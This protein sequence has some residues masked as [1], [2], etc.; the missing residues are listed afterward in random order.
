M[1]ENDSLKQEVLITLIAFLIIVIT[2]KIFITNEN[3]KN[4]VRCDFH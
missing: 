3:I 4:F 2:N 1:K